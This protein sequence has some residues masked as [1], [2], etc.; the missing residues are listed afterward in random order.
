MKKFIKQN[1][2]I[3]KPNK[4]YSTF[5]DRDFSDEDYEHTKITW[6]KSEIK[7]IGDYHDLY[8]KSNALFLATVFE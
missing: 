6:S 1:K 4:K 3:I 8:L 7:A 2:K 5:K